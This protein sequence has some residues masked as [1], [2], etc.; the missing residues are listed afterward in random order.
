[1]ARLGLGV[2]ALTSAKRDRPP[3]H[4]A[5]STI[6][7]VRVTLTGMNGGLDGDGVG[8]PLIDLCASR[9]ASAES[10]VESSS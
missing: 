10:Y 1:M 9:F 5:R 3:A 6:R 2:D 4:Q 8:D 7:E